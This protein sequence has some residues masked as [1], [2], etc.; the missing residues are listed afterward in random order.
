MRTGDALPAVLAS[1]AAAIAGPL[2]YRAVVINLYRPAWD[3]FEIVVVFGNEESRAL[4][5]G[6]TSRRGGL[7]SAARPALPAP[8]RLLRAGRRV[9]L[10]P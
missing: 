1:V 2:G 10:E 7:G 9:R 5:M 4:L 6:Q 3:D 8:R